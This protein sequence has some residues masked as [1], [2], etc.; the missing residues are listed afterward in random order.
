[1]K[2]PLLF[3][4]P[5]FLFLNAC[6]NQEINKLEE[7]MSAYSKQFKFNGTVLVVHKGKILL[8]KGYGLRNT[9]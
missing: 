4:I 6:F 3:V 5:F 1:M 7:L 8:D 2:K 9:S